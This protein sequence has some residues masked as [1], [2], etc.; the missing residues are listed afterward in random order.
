MAQQKGKPFLGLFRPHSSFGTG[1][2]Q[3]I[4]KRREKDITWNSLSRLE[5]PGIGIKT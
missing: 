4:E 1:G 5:E 3:T 2:L